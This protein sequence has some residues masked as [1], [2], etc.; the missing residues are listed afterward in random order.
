MVD[1]I[2]FESLPYD[3]NKIL[4][5]VHPENSD[6]W[7]WLIP[8]SN[9]TCSLGVVGEP[10]FFERYSLDKLTALQQLVGEEPAWQSCSS[11]RNTQMR[12]VN[13]VVTLRT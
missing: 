4:I 2:Q 7:Y 10:A 8:F 9:G 3:R 13:C 12:L 6:V 11:R 1:H 5:S